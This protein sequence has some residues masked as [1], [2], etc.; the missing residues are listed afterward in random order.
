MP[1][2]RGTDNFGKEHW[3]QE[4]GYWGEKIS[5][6]NFPP[7]I[8]SQFYNAI[9]LKNRYLGVDERIDPEIIP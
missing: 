8:A 9:T 4:S 7:Y 3:L 1:F 5:R 2:I 6:K